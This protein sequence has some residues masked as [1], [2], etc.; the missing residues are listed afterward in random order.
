MPLHVLDNLTNLSDTAIARSNIGLGAEDSP[1]FYGLTATGDINFVGGV[2]FTTNI[3]GEFNLTAPT[4]DL[5]STNGI[6]NVFSSLNTEGLTSVGSANIQ[7][8][9]GKVFSSSLGMLFATN[10]L[11]CVYST[12]GT[13]APSPTGL[14]WRG[15][16]FDDDVSQWK[17]QE[18]YDESPNSFWYGGSG[19]EPENGTWTSPTESDLEV[20]I[21]SL[22]LLVLRN[23]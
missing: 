9:V 11:P 19:S 7:S 4:I 15:V 20:T 1:E 22:F 12:D 8:D 14:N 2:D 10:G 18:Y 5:T 23:G 17:L 21:I 16:L 6:V 3:G 13:S